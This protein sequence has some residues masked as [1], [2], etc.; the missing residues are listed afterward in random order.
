MTFLKSLSD[1]QPGDQKVILNHLLDTCK[2]SGLLKNNISHISKTQGQCLFISIWKR[3]VRRLARL[4]QAPKKKITTRLSNACSGKKV[5]SKGNY[6]QL[7]TVMPGHVCKSRPLQIGSWK[8]DIFIV[9]SLVPNRTHHFISCLCNIVVPVL[10]FCF[11]SLKPLLKKHSTFTI[12]W[13][14][15]EETYDVKGK[16]WSPMVGKPKDNV[17]YI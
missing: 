4:D 7:V 15:C 11:L 8:P 17:I 6:H 14:K 9:M 16:S 5:C 12:L 13:R 10:S 2:C 1:L 3:T